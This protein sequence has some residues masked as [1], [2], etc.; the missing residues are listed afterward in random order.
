VCG[1]Q[2]GGGGNI[3]LVSFHDM[4]VVRVENYLVG[5]RCGRKKRWWERLPRRRGSVENVGRELGVGWLW[6]AAG[7]GKWTQGA[8]GVERNRG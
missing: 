8:G 2:G 5:G 1:S 6:G 3:L 7:G 4:L